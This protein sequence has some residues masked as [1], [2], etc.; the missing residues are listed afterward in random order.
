MVRVELNNCDFN[1]YLSGRQNGTNRRGGAAEGE[2][3]V[4]ATAPE[5]SGEAR[6]GTGN[7]SEV[8]FGDDVVES[9][10][11]PPQRSGVLSVVSSDDAVPNFD[12]GGDAHSGSVIDY[13]V[14]GE[15]VPA[16]QP[17]TPQPQ[18]P[19]QETPRPAPRPDL[20]AQLAA[21]GQRAL[22]TMSLGDDLHLSSEVGEVDLNLDAEY[23][24]VSVL[25]GQAQRFLAERPVVEEADVSGQ[26]VADETTGRLLNIGRFLLD[27]HRF[28][29]GS[30]EEIQLQRILVSAVYTRGQIIELQ[31]ILQGL[32]GDDP[33][34][35]DG[36]A[37]YL[38]ERGI[39]HGEDAV[40][41]RAEISLS[42]LSGEWLDSVVRDA[43]ALPEQHPL[44]VTIEADAARVRHATTAEEREN[45]FYSL[46]EN[47]RTLEDQ[48][49]T[50]VEAARAGFDTSTDIFDELLGHAP[51]RERPVRSPGE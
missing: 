3:A 14:D 36:V 22:A 9:T 19:V 17:P 26:P 10:F 20:R 5:E 38:S 23:E 8:V 34:A 45:A 1:S 51:L 4:P 30:R 7:P 11:I 29:P 41:G 16:P 13:I 47:Y 44:R 6:P 2:P 46:T 48:Y 15:G 27:N 25:R 42:D 39:R 32:R 18:P 24:E 31:H 33:G 49:P 50:R 37:D 21:A 12:F 40:E 35:F 43:G 28:M